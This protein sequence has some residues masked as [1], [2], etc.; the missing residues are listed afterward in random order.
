MREEYICSMRMV[1]LHI[2]RLFLLC[3]V[4]VGVSLSC[5]P[6]VEGPGFADVPLD[7]VRNGDIVFRRGRSFSSSIVLSQDAG[8]RY[9]HIGI[10]CRRDT[11]LYVIHAVNEEPDFKGDFDRVKIEPVESFFSPGRASAG[12]MYHSW[13][14]DS[15]SALIIENAMELVRDS[16]RFDAGFDHNDCGEL[17]C[18]ELI[19]LLYR[20]VGI[21]IT[22][23]RRTPVKL[24]SFPDEIIFP[25]DIQMNNNLQKYFEF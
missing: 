18:T 17:Y 3:A 20:N 12:A 4:L 22:E 15:L 25:N 10:V 14:S 11:A 24:F 1:M 23:G 9:S 19:Y 7:S 2:T 21:D 8:G 6:Q 13:V 16:V 5:R